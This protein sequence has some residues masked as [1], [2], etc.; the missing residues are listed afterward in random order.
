MPVTTLHVT[1]KGPTPTSSVKATITLDTALVQSSPSELEIPISKIEALSVTVEGAQAG[2]GV[3]A[4]TDF[5][6]ILFYSNFPLDF[7]KELIGQTG[8][9][10]QLPFGTMDAMG[11]GGD[12]NLK[13]L[14]SAPVGVKQFAMISNGQEDPVDLFEVVSIK[15]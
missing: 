3:Y 9:A 14:G 10:G 2:N 4:K 13:G 12:F 15:P 7:S 1:W 6:T 11:Q 5:S 8:D